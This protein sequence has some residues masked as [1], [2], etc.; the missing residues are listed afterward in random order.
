MNLTSR[1]AGGIG[2]DRV[3]SR[4]DALLVLLTALGVGY[5][6]LMLSLDTWPLAAVA[7]VLVLVAVVVEAGACATFAVVPLITRPLDRPDLRHGR[8]LR[9]PW[10]AVLPDCARAVGTTA[11]FASMAVSALVA[12]LATLALPRLAEHDS[13]SALPESRVSSARPPVTN[14]PS[15]LPL[16][17]DVS[18]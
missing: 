8:R 16:R 11:F 9:Q 6:V 7:V 15:P 14:R 18:A 10:S 17:E 5:G 1:P 2:S 12:G 3:G 4:R 13:D